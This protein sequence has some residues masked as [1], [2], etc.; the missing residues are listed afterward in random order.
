VKSQ[1]AFWIATAGGAGLVP[2]GPGTAGSL[3]AVAACALGV[4]ALPA[5]VLMLWP[6]V[7]ASE[8]VARER[9]LKDPQLVVIDEVVGQWIALAAAPFG[10]KHALAAFVLFRLFDITKPGP[11]RMLEK[12]PGGWGIVMDDVG[13]GILA[14]MVLVTARFFGLY[15]WL[16]F[17]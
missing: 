5:A 10:W 11:V 12:L 9:N 17:Y 14:A 3:V 7:W 1:L 13:A 6:S 16:N 4:P 8:V 15:E 2:K